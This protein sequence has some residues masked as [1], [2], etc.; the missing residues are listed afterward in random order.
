[1]P[2]T[3]QPPVVSTRTL[4]CARCGD[5]LDGHQLFGECFPDGYLNESSAEVHDGRFVAV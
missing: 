3:P 2:R 4:L 5:P 1:M